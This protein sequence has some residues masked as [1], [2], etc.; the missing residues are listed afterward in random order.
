M[1]LF[2]LGATSPTGILLVK[3]AL[4]VI[5]SSTIVI[6]ARSPSKLPIELSTNKSITVVQGELDEKEKLSNALAGVDAI[7]TALGPPSNGVHPAD[8]PLT[9][10]YKML[11]ALMREHAI[12]RIITLGTA[13]I[14]APEDRFAVGLFLIVKFVKTF[15][16]TAYEDLMEVGKV[17][18]AADDIDW[19]LVRV[20]Y[21]TDKPNKEVIVGFV[22]DGYVGST[23]ARVGYAAFCIEELL[24]PQWVR[25]MPALSS[26]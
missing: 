23:L 2:V 22:G 17:I 8:F 11:L 15:Y 25:R 6:Y 9:R 26:K 5:P 20:P 19:T 7:L 14:V 21:L 13:S 18:A 10:A 24:H 1:R 16:N 4:E 12:K 3:E